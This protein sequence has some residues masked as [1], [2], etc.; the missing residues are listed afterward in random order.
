MILAVHATKLSSERAD[1]SVSYFTTKAFDKA[2][3][4]GLF[5]LAARRKSEVTRP[6]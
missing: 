4:T 2:S 5:F 3:S 1:V 6:E